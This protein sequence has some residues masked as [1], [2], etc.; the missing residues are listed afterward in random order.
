M[1]WALQSGL[2]D[3]APPLPHYG[4]IGLQGQRRASGWAR[5]VG[6][7]PHFSNWNIRGVKA[8]MEIEGLCE[9]A[10]RAQQAHRGDAALGGALRSHEGRT[11]AA[12]RRRTRCAH[13]GEAGKR[14]GFDVLRIETV[15]GLV[16]A[17]FYDDMHVNATGVPAY[18]RY[19]VGQLKP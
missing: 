1:R 4:F 11:L 19:L 18:T 14:C 5:T 17:Q 12:R 3:S 9:M 8:R 15:P 10:S 16:D 7:H 6:E 13:L 2:Y